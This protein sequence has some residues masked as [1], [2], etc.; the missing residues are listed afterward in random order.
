MRPSFRIDVEC[1]VEAIVAALRAA[2]E[3]RAD[4]MTGTLSSRHCTLA[5]PDDGRRI[6]T[7]CLD[8]TINE[9]VGEDTRP[10]GSRVWGTFSPRAAIWTAF[11]FA[12]GTLVI[13]SIFSGVYGVAQLALGHVPSALAI[14]LAAALIMAL[15]YLVALVGQGLSIAD[16]YRLRAFVDDCL[17][18]AEAI[19]ARRPATATD[20]AQL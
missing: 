13:V 4:E 14:P 8:L 11:V 9:R 1:D 16:M 15:L 3:T 5:I 12:I 19:A 7:P 2:L 17:R 20:S 18:D 10:S 6:W